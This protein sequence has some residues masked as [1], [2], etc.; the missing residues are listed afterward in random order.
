MFF[1]CTLSNFE[2]SRKEQRVCIFRVCLA[3]FT[4]NSDFFRKLLYHHQLLFDLTKVAQ[5]VVQE[6][7]PP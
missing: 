6:T 1:Q 5:S 3:L 4:D 2:A 7:A